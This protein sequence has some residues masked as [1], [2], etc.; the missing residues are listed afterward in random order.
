MLD[1]SAEVDQTNLNPT[2]VMTY[3]VH[4]KHFRRQLLSHFRTIS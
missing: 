4:L 1:D 3:D 2:R